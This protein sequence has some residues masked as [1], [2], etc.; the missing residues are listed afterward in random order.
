MMVFD[1]LKEN[2]PCGLGTSFLGPLKTV[3]MVSGGMR[4]VQSRLVERRIQ[5]VQFPSY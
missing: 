2:I 3:S 5:N 4:S 1:A